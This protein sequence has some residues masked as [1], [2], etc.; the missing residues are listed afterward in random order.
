MSRTLP[1]FQNLAGGIGI[2]PMGRLPDH[3]LA[4]RCIA[5]LPTPQGKF[6]QRPPASLSALSSSQRRGIPPRA[7]AT[8]GWQLR[9]RRVSPAAGRVGSSLS[10]RPLCELA[11]KKWRTSRDSNPDQRFWRPPSCHWTTGTENGARLSAWAASPDCLARRSAWHS[12]AASSRNEWWVVLESNQVT[13]RPQIYSLLRSPMPPTTLCWRATTAGPPRL[14]AMGAGR[15][16]A[17]SGRRESNSHPQLGRLV[18][19]H[20]ATPA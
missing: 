19:D 9:T 1:R 7:I 17:W 12:T 2:E 16:C 18:P 20:S 3:G 11:S 13:R 6:T 4:N 10:G 5:A 8:Y 15:R 14:P